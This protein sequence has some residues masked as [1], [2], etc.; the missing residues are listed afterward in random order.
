MS[1]GAPAKTLAMQR[2]TRFRR[3]GDLG[4][5]RGFIG[6]AIDLLDV[7]EEQRLPP[8]VNRQQEQ[9]GGKTPHAR[10]DPV[11][12]STLVCGQLGLAKNSDLRPKDAAVARKSTSW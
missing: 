9:V 11:S 3:D 10:P 8:Q 5:S 4:G 12:S 6:T 2:M 1:S 7:V